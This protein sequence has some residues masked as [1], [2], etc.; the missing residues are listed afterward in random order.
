MTFS[1]SLLSRRRQVE[2]LSTWANKKEG[3]LAE[4]AAA[5]RGRV[6]VSVSPMLPESNRRASLD[7]RLP[8]DTLPV[9]L[10]GW[11]FL[12]GH[13]SCQAQFHFQFP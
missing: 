7:A 11:R 1:R 12:N 2:I 10:K 9:S 6:L 8:S 13:K 3:E 5:L 4:P